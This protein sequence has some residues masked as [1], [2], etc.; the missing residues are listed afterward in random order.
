MLA[1]A[2]VPLLASSGTRSL[3]PMCI[4]MSKYEALQLAQN[5][6][7]MRAVHGSNRSQAELDAAPV[8]QLIKALQRGRDGCQRKA[9]WRL[10]IS[11][12]ECD[13]LV[14]MDSAEDHEVRP[15]MAHCRHSAGP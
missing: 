14:A 15:S 10:K 5:R 4:S 6:I 8:A 3:M 9:Q 13:A 11:A 7:V 12:A 2:S 1:N